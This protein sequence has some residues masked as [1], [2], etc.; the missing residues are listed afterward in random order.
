MYIFIYF[1]REVC[2]NH[3]C[4]FTE[5]VLICGKAAKILQVCGHKR[6]VKCFLPLRFPDSLFCRWLLEVEVQT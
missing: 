5:D 4:F 1:Y 6:S 2:N 3:P